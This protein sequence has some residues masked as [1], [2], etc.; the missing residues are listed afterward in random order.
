MPLSTSPA[1]D[2]LPSISGDGDWLT[3]VSGSISSPY[4]YR[5][6][7]ISGAGELHD[8]IDYAAA[9]GTPVYASN[10]GTAEALGSGSTGGYGNAVFI[11]HASA[12]GLNSPISMYAHLQEASFSGTREVQKGDLIGYVGTTGM[13]TGCHLHFSIYNNGTKYANSIDP[14]PLLSGGG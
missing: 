11:Q 1:P 9:C 10:S 8:G 3:P 14:G 6:S 2:P 13:S 5:S 4:G 7:P 12:S